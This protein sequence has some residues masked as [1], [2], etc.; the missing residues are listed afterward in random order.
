MALSRNAPL[1]RKK[2]W[3]LSSVQAAIAYL[4]VRLPPKRERTNAFFLPFSKRRETGLPYPGKL[5]ALPRWQTWL[6]GFHHH[7]TGGHLAAPTPPADQKYLLIPCRP[8]ALPTASGALL[9]ELSSL[10][11]KEAQIGHQ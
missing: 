5:V 4:G 6:D 8:T 2:K 7:P 3:R 1:F 9:Q 10:D 11:P